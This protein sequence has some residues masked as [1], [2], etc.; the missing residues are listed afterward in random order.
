VHA[1][2]RTD[3]DRVLPRGVYEP[4]RGLHPRRDLLWRAVTRGND[5]FPVYRISSGIPGCSER[6]STTAVRVASTTRRE[7]L[8]LG[9]DPE[10]ART[11]LEENAVTIGALTGVHGSPIDPPRSPL[12]DCSL[13]RAD[14]ETRPIANPEIAAIHVAR[15]FHPEAVDTTLSPPDATVVFQCRCNRTK[16]PRAG[17]ARGVTA[18]EIRG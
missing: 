11:P 8:A 10:K 14:T 1:R 3:R 16:S 6:L 7:D 13:A 2:Q 9:A 15:M 18:P 17:H 12:L 5:Q 4:F